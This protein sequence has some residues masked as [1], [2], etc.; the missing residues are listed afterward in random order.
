[1]AGSSNRSPSPLSAKPI[2]PHP[3]T[4][5]NTNSTARRSFNGN[6]FSRPSVLSTHRG[7]NPVTPANS[8]ADSAK[9]VSNSGREG[10]FEEKENELKAVKLRSPAAKGSKNFMSPT[11]SASSKIASSPKK[12]ILVERNDPLR[13]SISLSDGKATFFN[14]SSENYDVGFEQ[15]NNAVKSMEKTEIL[16]EPKEE[17]VIVEEQGLTPVAKTPKKVTFLEVPLPSESLSDTVTMDSDICNDEPLSA[18]TVIAPLDADP[19]LPPYDPKTNYLS[20][21][22]QFLHYKPNPRIEVLLNKE[23]G[24]DVGGGAKSLDDSFLSELLLSDNIS[25][26]EDSESSQTA[27]ESPKESDG[28]SSE[29]MLLEAPVDQDEEEEPNISEPAAEEIAEAKMRRKPRSSVISKF[30]S[31]L[32]VLLVALVSISVTDSPLLA[33]TPGSIDLR[34]SNLSIPS[35][36]PVLA[37]ANS[38]FK[39]FSGEAISYFSKLIYDLGSIP[40]D[41]PVHPLKF[42]NLTDVQD[43]GIDH[44]YLKGGTG[45]VKLDKGLELIELEESETEPH[46]EEVQMEA[47]LDND[48]NEE[49]IEGAYELEIEETSAIQLDEENEADS[50][51]NDPE[52]GQNDL[53][54][55]EVSVVLVA[56]GNES[57]SSER[58]LDQGE[59][60]VA[61]T[62]SFNVDNDASF[63]VVVESVN[64][65]PES[66]V[67]DDSVEDAQPLEVVQSPIDDRL[68]DNVGAYQI[69]GISSVFLSVLAVIVIYLK[70]KNNKTLQPVVYSDH[71]VKEKHSS[72]NRPTEVDV[73]GESCPSEMS[74]FQISSSYSKKY[75]KSANDEAQSLEKKP[76]KSNRRE[77]LAAS[78]YSLGSPSYGSFTTYERIP[79]KHVS[80]G[81]EIITPV[82][83]S[84]RIK[85][86]IT[87]P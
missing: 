62:K 26:T 32:L 72:Q 85:S 27:D 82:R 51:E 12:K 74:S 31:V 61:E 39:Q 8:P 6:P 49:E 25:D 73:M 71:I 37:K 76:R 7:F 11:I 19:S 5:E 81:E 10:G 20:P 53:E 69:L 57:I 17:N 66:L 18:S 36:I 52:Q 29:E 30:F 22:P 3:R 77:S 24:L 86:H 60:E 43:S 21:R 50:S 28:S 54:T 87:S 14:A 70:M 4:S 34:F 2:P 67:K 41:I 1:M 13:T 44:W 47:D 83:R 55:E 23:K 35:D 40:S 84:S 78:E 56:E 33:T 80:G 59:H 46:E 75:P 45:S 42:M 63:D 9:R 68:G 65:N 79:I 64:V 48:G 58:D 16:L 38:Y 15:S